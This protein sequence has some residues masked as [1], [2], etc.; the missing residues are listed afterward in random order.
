MME[1]ESV[2]HIE[3]LKDDKALN[4]FTRCI[5]LFLFAYML[6]IQDM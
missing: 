1:R 4:L 3:E 2:R 5:S 6:T